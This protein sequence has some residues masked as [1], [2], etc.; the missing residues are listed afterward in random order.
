MGDVH[1]FAG[2]ILAGGKGTR[3][4]SEIGPHQKVLHSVGG[5]AL[6]EHSLDTLREAG[7]E[8]AT[9]NVRYQ[10]R[11][12]REWF[13][14]HPTNLRI[15]FS[16]QKGNPIRDAIMQAMDRTEGENFVCMNGDEIRLNLSIRAAVQEHVA[17][18]RVCT[19]IAVRSS[20][21]AR[22]RVLHVGEDRRLLGSVLKPPAYVGDSA[23]TGIVNAGIVI[24]GREAMAET[25]AREDGWSAIIDPLCQSGR[26]FVHLCEG[27]RYFNV[28]TPEELAEVEHLLT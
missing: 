17:M 26:A 8:R 12:V 18:R 28:G 27:A 11:E 19:V 2:I 1:S 24:L 22:H 21:L 13:R 23:S 16:R 14:H 10:E 7:I 4:R 9:V 3:L 25:H 5:K 15:R 6:I 20:H